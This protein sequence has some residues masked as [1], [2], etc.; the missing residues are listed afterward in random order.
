MEASISSSCEFEF[1]TAR[2]VGSE[3]VGNE[4]WTLDMARDMTLMRGGMCTKHSY[5]GSSL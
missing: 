2:D 4:G 1:G 5:A 3:G